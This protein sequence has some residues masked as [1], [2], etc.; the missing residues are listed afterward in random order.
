MDMIFPRDSY[1]NAALRFRSRNSVS[2][3]KPCA[4][5]NVQRI[6]ID[7]RSAAWIF[8]AVHFDPVAARNG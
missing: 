6:A 4:R 3:V 8:N 1:C 7:R 2:A 5:M